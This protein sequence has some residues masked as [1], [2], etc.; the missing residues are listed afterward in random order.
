MHGKW[1]PL[2]RPPAWPQGSPGHPEALALAV[3]AQRKPRA[4]EDLGLRIGGRLPA[5]NKCCRPW[6]S[7][8]AGH[9]T[10]CPGQCL[11]HRTRDTVG[12]TVFA[13]GAGPCPVGCL[14]ASLASAHYT[15][16]QGLP[17]PRGTLRGPTA[18][19]RS[20]AGDPRVIL[21]AVSKSRVLDPKVP[22]MVYRG[23]TNIFLTD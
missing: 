2:C 16:T 11:S 19:L 1:S 4:L 20:P 23:L 18:P 10:R 12:R 5:R 14:A 6:R 17:T 15:A 3:A 22:T 8:L 13:A 9:L 21:Q 7:H